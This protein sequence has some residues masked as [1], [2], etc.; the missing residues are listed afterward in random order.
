MLVQMW[1]GSHIS[2]PGGGTRPTYGGVTLPV[3][4]PVARQMGAVRASRLELLTIHL[5]LLDEPSLGRNARLLMKT[6]DQFN[7]YLHR[8]TCG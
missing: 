7:H 6:P 3:T 5:L 4:L 8:P 2:A 1:I